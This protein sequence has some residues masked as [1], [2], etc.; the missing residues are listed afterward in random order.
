MHSK[1]DFSSIDLAVKAPDNGGYF[2]KGLQ[3]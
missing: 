1:V 2:A 3:I